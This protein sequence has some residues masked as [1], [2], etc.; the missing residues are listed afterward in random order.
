[1]RIAIRHEFHLSASSVACG[2]YSY[3][4]ATNGSTLAARRAGKIFE[5]VT[6]QVVGSAEQSERR[7]VGVDQVR[8]P[9]DEPGAAMER[10]A[11]KIHDRGAMDRREHFRSIAP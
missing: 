4:S 8:D 3:P 11:R 6:Q 9:R 7:V 1:M 5:V 10:V 2:C